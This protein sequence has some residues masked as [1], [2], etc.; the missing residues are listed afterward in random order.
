MLFCST[1][2]AGDFAADPVNFREPQQDLI[3]NLSEVLR[4]QYELESCE[5]QQQEALQR[6]L[7]VGIPFQSAVFMARNQYPCALTD[8]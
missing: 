1:V 3:A 7:S 5:Q 8:R 4:E 2:T 6:F